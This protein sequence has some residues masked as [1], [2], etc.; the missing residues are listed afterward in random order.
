[1]S[2]T[3][4]KLVSII[5]FNLHETLVFYMNCLAILF[6]LWPSACYWFTFNSEEFLNYLFF[7]VMLQTCAIFSVKRVLCIFD[8][9]S[10]QFNYMIDFK[11]NEKKRKMPKI[12]VKRI[13]VNS[14]CADINFPCMNFD[15]IFSFKHRKTKKKHNSK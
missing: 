10:S 7:F 2:K 8:V 12:D 9:I 14:C 11:K 4:A 15:S 1:M 6:T 5:I 13:K 3:K